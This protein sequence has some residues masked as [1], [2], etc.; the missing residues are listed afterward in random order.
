MH[1]VGK[2]M[3][4]R[5]RVYYNDGTQSIYET[6]RYRIDSNELMFFIGKLEKHIPFTS[7]KNYEIEQLW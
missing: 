5:I 7:M 3:T 1:I 2:R 6:E 4:K